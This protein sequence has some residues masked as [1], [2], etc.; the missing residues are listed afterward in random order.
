MC[1]RKRA[2]ER[3]HFAIDPEKV[4]EDKSKWNYSIVGQVMGNAAS[5]YNMQRFAEQRWS[6]IGLMEVQ[7]LGEDLF[8]FRFQSEEAK[9]KE[10]TYDGLCGRGDAQE[11]KMFWTYKEDR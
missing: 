11:K 8:L 3:K 4:A 10:P 6:S 7:R 2:N 5:F 1:L 9:E